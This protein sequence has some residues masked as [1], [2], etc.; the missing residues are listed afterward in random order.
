V[1]A[2]LPVAFN[3]I[4]DEIVKFTQLSREQ[5][6]YR[7][8]M[9]AM[10]P[11]WNVMQDATRFGVTPHHYDEKMRQL[12]SDG[13][14]F[15]FET[16]AFWC[17]PTRKRVTEQALE[18]ILL[19]AKRSGLKPKDVTVLI[20][21]DGTGNDSL[22]L[23]NNGL[24][25]IYYDVPGSKTFDFAM[26]RFDYYGVLGRYIKT[27]DAYERCF[28]RQYDVV[29]SF[30]VLEHLPQPLVAI[31]DMVSLLKKGGIALITEDFGDI[32]N[33]LPTHIAAS[34]KYYGK[35]PFIFLNNGMLLRWYS[36]DPRFRPSEY[37]KQN[38]I[39][40]TDWLG[41]LRD[42]NVRKGYRAHY[43]RKLLRLAERLP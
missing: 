11:G 34:A 5:V 2:K 33:H 19:H 8:W 17:K 25:V 28:D 3:N 37:V 12:Y 35:I 13:D 14:G 23:A 1:K 26:K 18:R 20:I 7:L 24:S 32:T 36:E 38:K 9:E 30:N 31:G 41:L 6:E 21:G 16:L 40:L 4:V 27:I 43:T 39:M 29:I 42:R 10:V 15:I 22:Y